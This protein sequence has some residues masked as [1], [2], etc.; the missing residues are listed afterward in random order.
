MQEGSGSFSAPKAQWQSDAKHE[1]LVQII[2]NFQ[3]I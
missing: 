3:K 1:T 2:L